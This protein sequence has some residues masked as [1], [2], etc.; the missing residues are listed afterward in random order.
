MIT[1]TVELVKS[2][3][4]EI[5]THAFDGKLDFSKIK[6]ALSNTTRSLAHVGIRKHKEFLSTSFTYSC[7]DLKV[8]KNF[9]WT[10]E[11]LKNTIAHELIHIYE[12]QILKSKGTHG[13]SFKAQMYRLNNLLGY[14]VVVRA[15]GDKVQSIK[16]EEKVVDMVYALSEDQTK[17]I[18]TTPSCFISIN[19]NASF[20]NR[21]Q[22]FTVGRI[23]SDKIKKYAASRKYRGYH[24]I[25]QA[26]LQVLG[27]K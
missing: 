2:L 6:F 8:S 12:V 13:P 5:N 16:K 3:A 10:Q 14:N 4:E 26:E 1:L 18:F 11:A 21:F 15:K 7:E 19:R 17:V 27:I 25:T 22:K 23:K 9:Q 20:L 24:N